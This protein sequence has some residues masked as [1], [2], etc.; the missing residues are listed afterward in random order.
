MLTDTGE[1]PPLPDPGD[2]E[3]DGAFRLLCNWSKMSNDDPIVYPG[4]SGKAHHHTFF[5]NTGIDAFTTPENIRSKGNAGCRGGTINLSGYWVPSMVDTATGN[6]LAP[7]SLLIYYKTG[8]WTYMN[9]NSVIQ[10][11]PKGLKMITGNSTGSAPGIGTFQCFI[12]QTGQT[13]TGTESPSIPTTC[14]PG[15]YVRSRIAFPQCWDGVNLDS[16]DHKSHMATP[17]QFWTGD[18][19]RQY[20]CPLSH[21]VVLPLI[22][23]V[24][25]YYVPAGADTRAWRLSSD[26]Y[27]TSKPGGYSLHADWMNGW[28][29]TISDLWGVK[30][31]RERRNCGAANLGDGRV[32]AEFQGN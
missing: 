12:P 7:I 26:V 1:I 3:H 30:C 17:E 24:V 13:R 8:L 6:P 10:P 16:P 15:D 22:T 23:F 18:P 5:G 2:W 4:Q 32:T 31:L 11:V 28:D 19:N 25:D 14:L 29:P 20:R 27:D 9:D 21:P